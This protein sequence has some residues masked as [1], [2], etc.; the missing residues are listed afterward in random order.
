L[1]GLPLL[2]QPGDPEQVL[3]ALGRA[4]AGPAVLERVA[5][6]GD[7]GPDVLR[8]RL[9]DLRQRLLAGGRDR[10]V[11]IGGGAPDAAHV[12]AVRV[13]EPHDRA[14]LGGGGVVEAAEGCE[15]LSHA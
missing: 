7:G 1:I 14:R 3:G 8:A 10:R 11:G 5:R 6:G 15:L 12:Q 4:E 2:Q 9:S 13:V